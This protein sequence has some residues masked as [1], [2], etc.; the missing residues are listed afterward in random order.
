[1]T[2]ITV[3]VKGDV[4]FAAKIDKFHSGMGN[5]MEES[6]RRAVTYVWS[7]QPDYPPEPEGSTYRRTLTLGRT[8]TAWAGTIENALSRVEQA[9]GTVRAYYGS[10]LDYAYWVIDEVG[11]AWMHQ[12]RW[13]TAQKV[14]RD[15]KDG[16]V[17][18]FES[19]LRD[20]VRSIF[21]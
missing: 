8:M 15:A 14:V 4:E 1:M 19:G 21:R 3:N 17:R 9:F 5:A 20:Y 6:G 11:Q 10:M 18:A 2:K 16:I 13:W 7:Q 12:G